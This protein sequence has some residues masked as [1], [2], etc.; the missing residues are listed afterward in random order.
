MW[1]IFKK[2]STSQEHSFYFSHRIGY[3]SYSLKNR[4]VRGT[5]LAQVWDDFPT[6]VY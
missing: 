3:K 2:F 6:Y 1:S 5:G 4:V